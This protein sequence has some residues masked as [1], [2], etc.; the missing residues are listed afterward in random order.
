LGIAIVHKL[1][2]D[3]LSGQAHLLEELA[4]TEK[5]DAIH[6]LREKLASS[7]KT[8][9]YLQIEAR[10]AS[11]YWG[12]WSKLEVKFARQGSDGIPPHWR[13]FNQRVSP[14][15]SSPRNASNPANALLNYL[16]A[17]LE[18]ETRIA[19]LTVGLD[20]GMGFLHKDLEYRDSLALDIMEPVRA[21]VDSWLISLLKENKF[22][23]RD[24]FERR[25]GT[26]RISSRITS[27]LAET[28]P[29]W[30]KAVA[31]LT[32]WMAST[33]NRGSLD[34]TPYLKDRKLQKVP[35]PLTEA[36]RSL[37]R[38]SYRKR[39]IQS[40]STHKPILKTCPE[41][42]E[43]VK[44]SGREFCS[45][46]CYEKHNHE[47]VLPKLKK[48]GPR[49]MAEKRKSGIDLNHGGEV[50]AKRGRSNVKRF[51]ERVE[52]ERLNPDVDI[53]AEKTRFTNKLLPKLQNI[54]VRQLAKG[55]GLS[56]RYSSLIRRGEYT[57]HPMHYQKLEMLISMYTEN[58]G[59]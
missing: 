8:K 16:Y 39:N 1:L 56:L 37:G 5:A 31:P 25:D 12:A 14:L 50:A 10:A 9:H 22:N 28:S 57:P 27:I 54:P 4:F 13:I 33:L 29:L 30:R 38:D 21:I 51:H 41:C 35:T 15:T 58:D 11:I 44:K 47:V 32:E 19:C 42:G 40:R 59:G 6:K 43:V 55:S 48:A 24:F 17:I 3:K 52:W 53:P 18:A 20:P 45:R 2:A 7:K 23:K 46:A 49:R 34:M 36:N 26:V